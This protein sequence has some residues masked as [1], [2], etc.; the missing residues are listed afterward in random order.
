MQFGPEHRLFGVLTESEQVV[1][2]ARP[3]V[4]LLN[5]GA[6]HHVGPHRMNVT[7]SRELALLGYRT[8]S[9]STSLGSATAASRPAPVKTAST[10][11]DSCADVQKA[12]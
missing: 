12:P 9:A 10:P 6:N 5:V 3:T 2:E 1:G 7:L 4:I 8:F 11:K